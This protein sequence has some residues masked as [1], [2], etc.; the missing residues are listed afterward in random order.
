MD[1]KLLWSGKAEG[2]KMLPL[3]S[4]LTPQDTA[5]QLT[6]FKSYLNL[7]G[8]TTPGSKYNYALVSLQVFIL[9]VQASQVGVFQISDLFVL[10]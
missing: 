4:P 3:G 8:D 5:A 1:Y 2:I 10:V 7:I 6:T 9:F